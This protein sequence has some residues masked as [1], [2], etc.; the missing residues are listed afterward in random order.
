MHD[1][2]EQHYNYYTQG[3]I[4]KLTIPI[5]LFLSGSGT[6]K[7]RNAAEFSDTIQ[8]CFDG[9]FFEERNDELVT[10]LKE[11]F[12]FHV[13]LKEFQADEC[14]WKAIGVRMLVQLLQEDETDCEKFSVKDIYTGWYPPAPSQV[15]DILANGHLERETFVLVVDDLHK[16]AEARGE[17]RFFETLTQLKG[18]AQ[19][20]FILVCGTSAI[21]GP[22]DRFGSRRAIRLV[23]NPMLMTS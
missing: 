20:G 5:Y 9:T 1:E 23:C 17:I 4:D 2:V 8:K 7:S 14:P 12:V 13:S 6:G 22:I 11:S 16:I 3:F 10:R 21:S 15:I 18:L 19:C